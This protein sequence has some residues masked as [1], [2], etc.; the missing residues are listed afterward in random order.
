MARPNWHYEFQQGTPEWLAYR[1]GRITGTGIEAVM[2]GGSGVTR[3]NY[4]FKL[5]EEQDTGQPKKDKFSSQSMANGNERQPEAQRTYE[6]ALGVIVETVSFIDHPSI[7]MFGISPDGIVSGD[8]YRIG[9][10]LKC[11]ELAT[12]FDR[13]HAVNMV[14][15]EKPVIDRGYNLQCHGLMECAGLEAVDFVNW[16]PGH[17]PLIQRIHRDQKLINEMLH[18]VKLFQ[19][20]M[21]EKREEFKKAGFTWLGKAS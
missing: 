6:D 4:L 19:E 21:A 1:A 12:F 15:G 8:P 2:A 11:P 16:F 18:A 9:L 13:V 3:R 14:K 7:P 10:E 17:P 5:M 20:E